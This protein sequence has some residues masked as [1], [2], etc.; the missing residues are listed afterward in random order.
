[1]GT[2]VP[3]GG[4]SWSVRAVR[5]RRRTRERARDPARNRARNRAPEGSQ[6]LLHCSND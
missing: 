6:F 1:M 5:G 2:A 3:S 4:C